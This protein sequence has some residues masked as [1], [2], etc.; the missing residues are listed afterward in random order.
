MHIK[1]SYP[2]IFWLIITD[3]HLS[4]ISIVGSFGALMCML[5]I[6]KAKPIW[7]RIKWGHLKYFCWLI[8]QIFL[9]SI[10]VMLAAWSRKFEVE[11]VFCEIDIK[12]M[13]QDLTILYAH[14][15]TL[16]PG[17]MTVDVQK[18]HLLVHSIS[19]S[20][21]QELEEGKMKKRIANIQ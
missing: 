6:I 9:S 21:I 14:S 13:R 5:K 18:N 3:F 12:N 10:S 19:L 17:T 7:P 20:G 11:S 16:T 8:K 4:L 1:Y 15:I 2:L